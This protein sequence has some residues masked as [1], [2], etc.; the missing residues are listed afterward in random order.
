V[1][2]FSGRVRLTPWLIAAAVLGLSFPL[3]AQLRTSVRR[4]RPQVG[5]TA[6]GSSDKKYVPGEVLVRFRPGVPAATKAALHRRVG[7]TVLRTSQA[8][9]G[10]QRVRVQGTSVREA[11]HLYGQDPNVLYAEPNYVVHAFT[12]PNDPLFSSQWDLQNTGQMGGTPGADIH[13]TQAWSLTT[14][15]S[16]VVVA[17]VDTGV[18]YTHPD[19]G[20][21]VWSAAAPFQGFDINGNPLICPAGSRGFNA[22][23]GLCDPMDD[24]GH[25]THVSGTIGALGN[26]GQG[27]SGINWQVQILPCKFLGSDGT[28]SVGGAIE[29][30]EVI[31]SLKDSGTNII[32]TND[33]W[34]GVEFS[35]AL[36][37]AVAAQLADGILFIAAAGNDFTNN[38]SLPTY[39]A[40]IPLPNVL[41][42][43]ATDRTDS[44]ATFSNVGRHTVHLAA[45]GVDILSTTP[46]DTYSLDSGTSMATPHVTGVAALLKA[47]DP[48]RDW[49]SIKNLLL[50]GGD[51]LVVL[52]PTVT[53]KRL[54]AY[55]SM[56]CANRPVYGRLQPALS[57]ISGSVGTPLTLSALNINCDQPAGTVQVT[58][59]PGG[60]TITLVDNG[61]GA[62]LAAGDGVYTASWTPTALGNY[63]LTFPSGDVIAVSVLQN[64]GYTTQASSSYISF[65]GA[66]LNLGD[67][68]IA[69]VA[70]PFPIAFGG[71]SFSTL[72]VGSNGI[73]SFTN[74]F[75]EY[76]NYPLPIPGGDT[77][78][79]DLPVQT[80]VAPYWDDLYPV[81]GTN[82]NVF[83]TVLGAAPNRQLVV[84]WRNVR[85]YDCRTD[86]NATI[87]F[88]A[89]FQEGSGNVLFNYANTAFGDNCAFYDAG[90]SATVGIQVAPTLGTTWSFDG[91][92]VGS[93]TSIV[94]QSPPPVAQSN[95]VPTLSALSPNSTVLGSSSFTL[96]LTGTNFVPGASIQW[97]GAPR[98]ATFVSSSQLT[99]Q[100]D[101]SDFNLYDGAGT[102][103]I[104]VVNPAPGGGT[105]NTL[106]FTFSAPGPV[107]TALSPAS[108]L[109]GGFGF[110]LSVSGS[111]FTPGAQL[112]W[113]GQ[114]R[115]TFVQNPNLLNAE[116]PPTDIATAGTASVTVVNPGSGASNAVNFSVLPSS[117]Q[118][119]NLVSQPALR[120]LPGMDHHPYNKPV[121]FLGWKLASRLGVDYLQYFNRPGAGLALAPA[122]P[123]S[124]WNGRPTSQAIS[125]PPLPGF[126]LRDA[127]PAGFIPSGVATADFNR[128]GHQ[129]WVVANG[130]AN[131][132][133]LYLGKGD[134]TSQLPTIIPLLGQAPVAVAAADLRGIGISDLVV[135]EADSGA[136]GVFLGNGDGTFQPEKE[137][138][139][140]G[141]PT[142]LAVAD[143]NGDGH[144]DIVAGTVASAQVNGFITLLGDGTG[145]FGF[146][147]SA[148]PDDPFD[149]PFVIGMALA[150]FNKD[151]LP[152]I[153]YADPG[154]DSEAWVFINQGDGTFKRSQL[155]IYGFSAG[156]AFITGVAAGDLNSDGCP[157]AVVLFNFGA[158]FIYKGDCSGTFQTLN[159]AT[160][161]LGDAPGAAAVLDVNGDGFPDLVISGVLNIADSFYGQPAGD[162]LTVLLND[163]TGKLLPPQVYRGDTSMFAL[164]V[165]DIN[166][167]GKPDIVTANQDSDSATVFLNDGKGGYGSP[168]GGYVGYLTGGSTGTSNAPAGNYFIISDLNGDGHPDLAAVMLSQSA[169]APWRLSTLLNDGTGHFAAPQGIDIANFGTAPGDTVFADFRNVGKPD[170]LEIGSIF[171][172]GSPALI[173]A[174]NHGDGT[175]A[176]AVVTAAPGAQGIIGVGDFNKDG[177]LDFVVA[178]AQPG[179]LPNSS[180]QTLT[181]FFGNGDGTFRQG[182][183]ITYDPPPNNGGW[184]EHIV[185]GDFNHDGNLDVLVW[186]FVNVVPNPL[187]LF[188]LL[189]NGDGTFQPAKMVLPN[190]QPFA[191][192]DLNHDGLPDLVE[193]SY[194]EIQWGYAAALLYNIYTGQPDGS[195]KLTNSYQPYTG[196]PDPHYLFGEGLQPMLADFNGDGQLDIAAFQ[197]PGAARNSP[198]G[199]LQVMLGNGDATFTPSYIAFPLKKLYAPAVAV[200]VN[201]DGRADLIELDSLTSSYHVI[202]AV[203]GP[204]FQARLVANPVVEGDGILRI[205]QALAAN[206]TSVQLV[207]SDPAITV[208]ATVTIP[209]GQ[210][211][212]DVPFQI[213]ANFNINRVFSVQLQ[214]GAEAHTVYGYAANPALPLGFTLY[215]SPPFAPDALPGGTTPTF[216]VGVTSVAGYAS[217]LALS[218]Q[219]LPAGATCNIGL[220]SI[221]LPAGGQSGQFFTVTAPSSLGVGTYPFKV[222]ATDGVFTQFAA[223]SFSVEDFSLSASTLSLSTLSTATNS[224]FLNSST[225]VGNSQPIA[226]TCLTSDPSVLCQL[227]APTLGVGSGELVTV[228]THNTKLGAYTVTVTGQV[229]SLSHS[230]NIQL[231]VGNVVA[232]ISPASV[233]ASVGT[234]TNFTVTLTSQGG[235]TGD[236]TFACSNDVGGMFCSANPSPVTLTANGAVS[237]TLTVS[238]T[239]ATS[240]PSLPA[241]PSARR[242]NRLPLVAFR[243]ALATAVGLAIL[244]CLLVV[245]G[246]LRRH[247]H[248]ASAGAG[249]ARRD[250]TTYAGLVLIILVSL[251]LGS[252][253]GAGGS[254]G[255]GGS[256]GGNGGG[257]GSGGSIVM[258][259]QVQATTSNLT[260]PVGTVTITIP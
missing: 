75:G 120:P 160:V 53:G 118:A 183:T 162:L 171:S 82:Q 25:G 71:G 32:A 137:Y 131:T 212:L 94:W 83:W 204:S 95:P 76:V 229:G 22:V 93:N 125:N 66:N 227:Q 247:L 55:G 111:N 119:A 50:A 220:T 124:S 218:C 110:V 251:L 33:S 133:W 48:T 126:A 188:E 117:P 7:A 19:L 254:G 28:G 24:N 69:S 46:N 166:G 106:N 190:I 92:F 186:V 34:G 42:V 4:L 174:K 36:Q 68:D 56:T 165:A 217:D 84:E 121:R 62:D 244:A 135:A 13:A 123:D 113:N 91:Q 136:I 60:Q 196:S 86:S 213:A 37:D 15:S 54:N 101:A 130:G 21:N 234:Q 260:I 187:P 222:V 29:C 173:Y 155:L 209:A 116:I 148:P 248:D 144:L 257:G 252:C 87:Q 181:T 216:I 132:L 98:A 156:D 192:G 231:T 8:V 81:K 246:F 233:S 96:A 61:T 208:P 49:R 47:Q 143:L 240:L 206:A 78:S 109:A 88:E 107:I 219:G 79:R 221:D 177:K 31:K 27:V 161:G 105:S 184:A 149:M 65:A 223:A 180:V 200:D 122:N 103:T 225:V 77:P 163:G 57:E 73:I 169:G 238:V 236:F 235:F 100:I 152:D 211:S 23:Y 153:V 151:G 195:F 74:A 38:D 63:T 203:P 51:S 205:T 232:S 12:T 40:N 230:L 179:S 141:P 85:H 108:A 198:D 17:V 176:P 214:S 114:T 147:I 3:A 157:D 18:D 14:G 9:T 172:G 164:A 258:H 224:F 178:G 70:S 104:S 245:P 202:P 59:A 6:A 199:Y 1:Q 253:G 52:S 189:G 145:N 90:G 193:L 237:T 67:D 139:V 191:V 201:G 129:D 159:F 154:N 138:Y 182:A 80:L 226:I 134:G 146:P 112:A 102:I 158:A 99:A 194:Q 210:S 243:E 45:P 97:N 11:I 239:S 140:P 167:D 26:N 259:V 44:L 20:Q 228:V 115:Q 58:V 215:V 250:T 150:D 175:F 89:V 256:G 170:F 16:N 241:I 127:L 5:G 30:L 35:Q 10:L 207:A 41:A 2:P 255:S 142:T 64:Y 168:Q 197:T 128:D 43:A 39:P 242:Q 249:L 72:Y 185:V